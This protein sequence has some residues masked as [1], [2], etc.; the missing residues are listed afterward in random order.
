[1]SDFDDGAEHD[2]FEMRER[3]RLASDIVETAGRHC[4]LYLERADAGV[5][6]D[7]QPVLVAQ[8]RVGDLAFTSRVLDPP[9]EATNQVAREMEVDQMLTDFGRIAGQARDGTGILA[10]LEEDDDGD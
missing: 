2:D 6:P 8:F 9:A 10:E 3:M 1:M 5:T 4:G 7:G